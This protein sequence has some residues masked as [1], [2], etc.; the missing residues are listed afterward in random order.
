MCM[1]VC[2]CL[3]VSACTCA[4]VHV[5]CFCSNEV[6]LC[7]K[8][9]F[10]LDILV[11]WSQRCW[12]DKPAS[13]WLSSLKQIISSGHTQVL[14]SS[15][16]SDQCQT[17]P[18]SFPLPT[19]PGSQPSGLSGCPHVALGFWG[20][21]TGSEVQLPSVSG[22]PF[23]YNLAESCLQQTHRAESKQLKK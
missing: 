19:S 4:G 13:L 14:R 8:V 20:Y 15:Q 7:S 10:K 16:E 2:A 6:L 22:P 18:D 17:A 12:G 23:G 3:C 9:D 1:P 11:P 5:C 21:L